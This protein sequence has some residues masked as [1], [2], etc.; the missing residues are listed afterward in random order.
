MTLDNMYD[1]LKGLKL[2]GSQ[3]IGGSLKLKKSINLKNIFNNYPNQ[4]RTMLKNISVIF[5][6]IVL[7]EL[8]KY[9]EWKNQ[10][11]RHYS[12]SSRCSKGFRS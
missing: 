10:C 7:L 11:C 5:L 6:L 2:T 3:K 1:D 8:W 4:T 9:R 12:W